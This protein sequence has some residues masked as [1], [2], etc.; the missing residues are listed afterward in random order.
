[1]VTRGQAGEKRT[2]GM[3]TVVTGWLAE[4]TRRGRTVAVALQ[5]HVLH[6]RDAGETV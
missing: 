1:M 2:G 5:A 4:C 6:T 3:H